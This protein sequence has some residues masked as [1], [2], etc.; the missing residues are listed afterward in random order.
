[1]KVAVFYD[2]HETIVVGLNVDGSPVDADGT[3][4]SPK[5]GRDMEMFE[6]LD[7]DFTNGQSV[8]IHSSSTAE[9]KG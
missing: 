6:R 1:M 9:I 8:H 5:S 7:A 3:L 4:F 2:V